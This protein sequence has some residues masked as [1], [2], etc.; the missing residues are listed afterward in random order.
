MDEALVYGIGVRLTKSEARR[1]EEL[2]RYTNRSKNNVIR[3]LI[4]LASV[5]DAQTLELVKQEYK[6]LLNEQGAYD[7]GL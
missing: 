2:A 4:R 3:C 1:L 7:A 5:R 6:K